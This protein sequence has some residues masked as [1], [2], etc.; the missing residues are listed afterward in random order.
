MVSKRIALVMFFVGFM[1]LGAVAAAASPQTVTL[2]VDVGTGASI[3]MGPGGMAGSV[4]TGG[5]SVS[6]QGHPVGTMMHATQ[7]ATMSGGS[8]WTGA[9][10]MILGGTDDLEGMSGS[11]TVGAA[12]G[13]TSFPFT[14]TINRP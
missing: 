8:P 11:V 3:G 2:I 4:M 10:G 1:A 5:G 14:F 12:V 6:S 9:K 13:P 7:T